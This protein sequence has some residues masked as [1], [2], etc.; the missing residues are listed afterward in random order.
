MKTKTIFKFWTICLVAGLALISSCSKEQ[1]PAQYEKNVVPAVLESVSADRLLWDCD[2]I[3]T[4]KITLQGQGLVPETVC[5]VTDA[6]PSAFNIDV[7]GDIILVSPKSVNADSQNDV[8]EVLSV[9]ADGGDIFYVEL[10]QSR[11]N[12]PILTGVTPEALEWTYDNMDKK[13][14]T[15]T[16]L[17]LD[18]AE[19]SVSSDADDS[20]FIIEVDDKTIEV[21]PKSQN[22]SP[23]VVRSEVITVS[24]DGGNSIAFTAVQTRK[25]SP[26]SVVYYTGF[27]NTD[28]PVADLSKYVFDDEPKTY[29]SD[30]KKWTMTYADVT[31]QYVWSGKTSHILARVYRD[32]EQQSVIYSE[33]LLSDVK[34][35][36]SFSVSLARRNANE[37]WCRVEY[38]LDG[39]LWTEAGEEFQPL[40][41]G[42]TA[43]D[44]EFAVSSGDTGIFMIRVT[45]FFKEIPKDNAFLNFEGVEVMGY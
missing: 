40:A 13:S 32:T 26:S 44:Y 21:T 12:K 22:D 18:G 45:Y 20:A 27:D 10:L 17:N 6:D 29:T 41:S 3:E 38:S 9:S 24:V 25:P 43:G 2:G 34:T 11:M 36:T 5:A 23:D 37:G 31:A 8:K 30:G 7:N 15:V 1:S 19:L 4:Y 28:K 35:V 14:V 39:K 33:N 42:T 16:G